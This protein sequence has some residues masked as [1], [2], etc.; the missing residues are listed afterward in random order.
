VAIFVWSSPIQVT[1]V[2][3]IYQFLISQLNR[4]TRRKC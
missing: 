1:I 2:S 3:Q 4:N